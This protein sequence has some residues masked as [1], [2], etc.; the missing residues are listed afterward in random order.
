MGSVSGHHLID[1]GKNNNLE[2]V[3][4]LLDQKFPINI[5]D[6]DG[7]TAPARSRALASGFA[8]W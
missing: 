7:W 6:E 1:A 4:R 3:T 5:Q 2:G 8:H